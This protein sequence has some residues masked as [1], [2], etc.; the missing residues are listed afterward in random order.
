LE[1]AEVYCCTQHE[2]SDPT[3]LV[4]NTTSAHLAVAIEN[5]LTSCPHPLMALAIGDSWYS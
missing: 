4:H 2:Q 5:S 1:R 3:V